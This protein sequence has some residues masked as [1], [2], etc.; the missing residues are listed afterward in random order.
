MHLE[1]REDA[2]DQPDEPEILDDDRVDAAVDR[3]AEE[4]ERIAQLDLYKIHHFDNPAKA[5]G[6]KVLD[7]EEGL[8]LAA[9]KADL[10]AEKIIEKGLA[11]TT[12]DIPIIGE[13]AA[14]AGR[15]PL[16]EGA[17]YF[18][19]VDPLDGTREFITGSGDYTVNIALIHNGV[20][21]LGVVY[22]PVP[23]I[24]YAGFGAG[25]A[26]KWTE[27][28]GRDKE[29]NV[30]PAPKEGM[31][32]V[33]SKHH[34]D[35]DKLNEFLEGFKVR[36]LIRRGSSLKICAVAEGKADLYPRFGPT[37]EWDTAAGD[38]VLRAAGGA[39]A[40]LDGRPFIYGRQDKK[41]LNGNF[42]AAPDWYFA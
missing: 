35:S 37:C 20:P 19:L 33:A 41:F 40:D 29:I 25:R 6:L 3:V 11:N 2:A 31:T 22:A 36:K 28:T 14:A 24:L 13:E 4:E 32:V 8:R 7:A 26:L 10:A 30:R 34:G 1:R 5:T 9:G 39:I 23:G 17:E 21:V 38:A 27:D 12:P 18:W 42:I 16:L 15:L